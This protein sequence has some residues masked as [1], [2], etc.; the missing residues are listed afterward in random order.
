MIYRRMYLG[1][2]DKV[3]FKQNSEVIV[4]S[5]ARCGDMVFV[6]F[7][8]KNE[9]LLIDDV[10]SGDMKKFPDGE[11]FVRMIRVFQA[12]TPESESSYERKLT[13]KEPK[14]RINYIRP[15]ME[16]SYITYHTDFQNSNPYG[17]DK[18]FSIF[19]YGNLAIIY[20][21]EPRELITLDEISGK[22]HT[23]NI[24]NWDEIMNAHFIPHGKG[25]INWQ[26][27][28]NI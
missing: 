12:F 11:S 19:M 10:V 2:G 27:L 20:N 18:F 24:E 6:Y 17:W 22:K 26:Y 15:D 4:C 14:F 8:T 16:Q 9:S 23:P 7:E 28:D 13:Q 21:E 3:V 1:Y 5:G 25:E